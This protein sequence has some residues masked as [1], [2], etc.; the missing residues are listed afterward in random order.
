MD[1]V[2]VRKGKNLKGR[3]LEIVLGTVGRRA[4][5]KALAKTAK[6]IEARNYQITVRNP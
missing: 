2:V 1:A 4:L 5:A 3:L 6:A